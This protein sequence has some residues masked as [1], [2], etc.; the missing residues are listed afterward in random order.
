MIYVASP[1]T[2]PDPE[3]MQ[4]RWE[5]AVHTVSLL[6]KCRPSVAIYSPIVHWHLVAVRHNL[7]RDAGFWWAQNRQMLRR[8]TQVLVLRLEGWDA[9]KGIAQELAEARRRGRD[10]VL[11]DPLTE[12]VPRKLVLQ[13]APVPPRPKPPWFPQEVLNHYL[14]GSE[15]P[16]SGPDGLEHPEVY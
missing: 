16:G 3:V 14:E 9:S 2:D 1:Y 6:A 5:Q 8:C 10:I 11:W 4:L 7:P 15:S 12:A 13:P